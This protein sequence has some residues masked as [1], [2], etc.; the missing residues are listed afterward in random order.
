MLFFALCIYIT[1]FETSACM[2]LWAAMSSGTL[3][4]YTSVSLPL[5]AQWKNQQP[6][7]QPGG[8]AAAAAA[9]AAIYS[10]PC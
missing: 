5:R 4:N 2:F 9:T 8:R 6:A 7:L 1:Y 10:L 3:L